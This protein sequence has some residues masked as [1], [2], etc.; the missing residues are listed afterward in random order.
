M[1][2][3]QVKDDLVATR[4]TSG[5]TGVS[6]RV[7]Q[8]LKGKTLVAS[9]PVGVPIGEWVITL[10]GSAARLAM[11]DPT[12]LTDLSIAGIIDDWEK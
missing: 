8:D 3:M 6:L 1:E 11:P 9:D 12:T 10:S 5:L 4:C 7:L 2:I